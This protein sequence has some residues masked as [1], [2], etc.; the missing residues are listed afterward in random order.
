VKQLLRCLLRFTFPFNSKALGVPRSD[1]TCTEKQSIRTKS[2]LSGRSAALILRELHYI[3]NAQL[4]LVYL[5]IYLL[6][7]WLVGLF[8]WQYQGLN[9]G[10]GYHLSNTVSSASLSMTQT[11]LISQVIL[12]WREEPKSDTMKTWVC[13]LAA[14]SR[15]S[16][17]VSAD[18]YSQCMVS[19]DQPASQE[20]LSFR[21]R[22]T[23]ECGNTESVRTQLEKGHHVCICSFVSAFLCCV[24]MHQ[25][26]HLHACAH[27]SNRIYSHIENKCM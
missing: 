5:F 8:I 7:G 1:V 12:L 3:F 26:C 18:R 9:S 27:I 11:N 6:V 25:H 15:V 24:S 2:C 19:Y 10:L 13:F 16:C 23:P 20:S 14:G 21:V 4:P 22:E 17:F